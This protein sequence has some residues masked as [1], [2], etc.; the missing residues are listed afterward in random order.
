MIYLGWSSYNNT[1]A[2]SKLRMRKAFTARAL[3]EANALGPPPSTAHAI[4][5]SC[6]SGMYADFTDGILT[7]HGCSWNT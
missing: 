2:N 4:N 7:F 6:P 3:D 1:E 5:G